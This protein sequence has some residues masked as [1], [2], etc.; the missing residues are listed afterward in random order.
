MK[1]KS[2]NSLWHIS[3]VKHLGCQVAIMALMTRPTMN[4][5]VITQKLHTQL[6]VITQ[7]L[8]TQL[9]VITQKLHTQLHV[10][11]Q[12]LNTQLHV[13]TQKLHVIT[14]KKWK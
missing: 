1:P 8:N 11:T 12:K 14:Q 5:P 9:H 3:Q 13:N 7:K 6:H 10:I 4:S 2:A